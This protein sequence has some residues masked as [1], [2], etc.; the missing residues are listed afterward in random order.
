MLKVLETNKESVETVTVLIQGEDVEIK[1][2]VSTVL[3]HAMIMTALS[4]SQ[5]V[6]LNKGFSRILFDA[7]L[8]A[9]IIANYTNIEFDNSLSLLDISDYINQHGIIEL[10]IKE[11]EELKEGEIENLLTYADVAYEEET[12]KHLSMAEVARQFL[13]EVAGSIEEIAPLLETLKE[14]RQE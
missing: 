6:N 1:G 5:A 11:I 8:E 9:L 10:V 3:K 2:Y 7:F 13:K 12:A 14:A 4:E